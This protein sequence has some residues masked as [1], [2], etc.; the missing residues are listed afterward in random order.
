MFSY[1]TKTLTLASGHC[2]REVRFQ[3]LRDCNLAWGLAI[4]TWFDD[5]DHDSRSQV[6][7]NHKVHFLLL[8]LFVHCSLNGAWLLHIKKLKHSLLCVTG[9]Y[10]R[11]IGNM[12]FFLCCT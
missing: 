9:V 3:T 4:H 12:I 7:E 1:L 8:L 2:L 10:L 11:D 6:C 5:L